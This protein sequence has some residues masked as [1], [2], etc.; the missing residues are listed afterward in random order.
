[1]LRELTLS[2]QERKP[3]KTTKKQLP[4]AAGNN[5]IMIVKQNSKIKSVKYLII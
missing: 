4:A 3:T 1:M 5:V 2:N